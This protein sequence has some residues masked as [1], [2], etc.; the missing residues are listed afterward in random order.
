MKK[1]FYWSPYLSN[2][3]TIRNVLN[4]AYSLTKY[5]KNSFNTYLLD[6]F[7]EWSSFKSDILNKKINYIELSKIKIN[8]PISGFL[9]SRF[10]SIF[11]FVLNIFPLLA[12]LKKEKP[13]YLIIHLLTSIP[14]TLLFFFKFETK[15]I[16]RI[17]G[18]PKLNFFRKFLWKLVSKKIFL[19]TCPSYETLED[20]KKSKIFDENKIVVLYDPIINVSLINKKKNFSDINPSKKEYFLSIGRLTKQKNHHLLIDL[21]FKINDENKDFNLYILGE[22][23]EEKSL[24]QKIKRYNLEDK[25][26]LLGFKE[27][28]YPYIMSSRAI[29]SSSLWEDP[30]AVMIEAAFCNKIVLSSDCKNGPKEFLMNNKAGYLFE[31]NNLESLFNSWNGLITDSST[32]V[33]Q[34]KILAKKNSR[35][36]SIFNHYLDLKN[37]LI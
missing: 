10:L 21:F 36:Y 16:L 9:K 3:A 12:L 4:S 35:R 6:V 7:G 13:H 30:G 32:K 22:G 28:V 18:L 33:Y 27:N 29:I 1:I 26:F 15:F 37:F 25:V 23:E 19:I 20:I 2:V 8:L 14:L 5:G 34:K 24:K 31:N 11:I 17:S